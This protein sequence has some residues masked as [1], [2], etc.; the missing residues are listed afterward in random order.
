MKLTNIIKRKK[1]ILKSEHFLK[2]VNILWDNLSISKCDSM[3]AI[4][5]PRNSDLL[6][7][8]SL[9]FAVAKA[10]INKKILLIDLNV[11][12]FGLKEM[13][14]LD[15]AQNLFFPSYLMTDYKNIFYTSANNLNNQNQLLASKNFANEIERLNSEFDAIIFITSPILLHQ[16]ILTIKEKISSCLIIVEKG[17]TT[18]KDVYLSNDFVFKHNIPCFGTIFLK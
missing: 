17:H 12:G 4:T 7:L 9:S 5:T 14:K 13:L 15:D 6:S 8:F 18:R 1:S 3:I 2:D 11:D 16:N 10:N